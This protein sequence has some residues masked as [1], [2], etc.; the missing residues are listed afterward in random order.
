MTATAAQAKPP[1]EP[2]RGVPRRFRKDNERAKQNEEEYLDGVLEGVILHLPPR[3]EPEPRPERVPMRER[4]K[5]PIARPVM[6]NPKGEIKATGAIVANRVGHHFFRVDL[7]ARRYLCSAGRGSRRLTWGVR[8]YVQM[9]DS[10]RALAELSDGAH[11]DSKEHAKLS[12]L[13]VKR[14]KARWKHVRATAAVAGPTALVVLVLLWFLLDWLLGD[15]RASGS[16]PVTVLSWIHLDRFL[17]GWAVI[18]AVLAFAMSVLAFYGRHRGKVASPV[19]QVD[20]RPVQRIEG[21]PSPELIHQAFDFS[22]IPGIVVEL[23]PHRVGAGWETVVRI[24]A[25]KQTFDDAVKFHGAIAGNLGISGECLFLTPIRGA[26]GSTKHVRIWYTTDADPFTGDPPPHPLMDPRSGPVDL[27]NDGLPI[28]LD[29]RGSIARIAVV[30]TPF[31]LVV[32]EPGSGK[33][34]LSFGIGASVGADPLW[35][36]DTWTF[37]PSDSFAPLKPLVKACGGTSDYGDDKATFDRFHTY[38]VKLKETLRERGRILDGLPFDQN[39]GD[40][41]DRDVA[42]RIRAARP[43]IVLAD[44]LI[45]VIEMDKRIL[46]LLLDIA[47]KARSQHVVFVASAQYADKETFKKLQSLFGARICFK[48]AQH[49][50]AET[51][52]GGGYVSGLTEPHRIPLSAVAVAF[53][54]GTIEDPDLGDRPAFKVRLFDTDRVKVADHVARCLA[55]PRADQAKVDLA[56]TDDPARTRLASAMNG[57]RRLGLDVLAERFGYGEGAGALRKAAADA[58]AAGVEPITETRDTGGVVA[59]GAKYVDLDQLNSRNGHG[60]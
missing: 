41:V 49:D 26:G 43:R 58:R 11:P 21:R 23:A 28:G 37:K 45:T 10:L 13:Y 50:E 42:I 51:A 39:P 57:D 9:P 34:F 20:N 18:P 29:V 24:P 33:T 6:R 31:V 56:K 32:G 14:H 44:E 12:R 19:R 35:D 30:D 1:R 52:L 5:L 55:G 59:R 3:P 46:P 53:A 15:W 22:G 54:A 17:N 7:H 60:S 2:K 8:D 48:V 27:W 16:A 4:D 40:K 25:G 36:L 38:L 47:R